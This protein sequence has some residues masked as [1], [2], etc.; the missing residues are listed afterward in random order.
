MS[1]DRAHRLERMRPDTLFT[2][3]V[4]VSMSLVIQ[5]PVGGEMSF[6]SAASMSESLATAF[7]AR[8]V[9]AEAAK[10]GNR[11]GFELARGMT[12]H[13][14]KVRGGWS[15]GAGNGSKT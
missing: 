14:K 5:V 12:A 15:P 4:E 1:E 7:L 11:E 13:A 6:D 8:A 3:S 10:S 9:T 2:S